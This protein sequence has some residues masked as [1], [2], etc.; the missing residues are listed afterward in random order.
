MLGQIIKNILGIAERLFFG[1]SVKT[2]LYVINYHGTPENLMPNFERHLAYYK[3]NFRI[4]NPSDFEAMV[5][6]QT[7]STQQKPLLLLTF[8]D[9]MQNNLHVMQSLEKNGIKA[10]FFVIPAFIDAK[11]PEKYL[12]SVIRPGYVNKQEK[13]AEDF[14]PLS[15]EM[16]KNTHQKGHTI[17][18]HTYTHSLLKSDNAQ[19][20]EYEILESKHVIEK[21]LDT[22]ITAFCSINNTEISV[23]KVQDDIIR[24]NYQFHFT[25]YYGDNMPLSDPYRIERINIEAYWNM[26]E[27]CYAL[28]TIRKMLIKK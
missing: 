3:S 12:A 24:A 26:N 13:A 19:R 16:I 15:W 14:R 10:Y 4:I 6:D 17:G 18:S 2:G 8:D 7:S 28:G 20:S 21:Y 25:T 1:N 23:G 27:V 22:S 5:V 9:G 11:E